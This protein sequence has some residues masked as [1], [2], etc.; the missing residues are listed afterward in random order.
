MQS[1]I[2]ASKELHDAF[3]ALVS[4]FPS[5]RGLI[6]SIKNEQLVPVETIKSSSNDFFDDLKTLDSLIKDN[7]AAY[8]VL[9]RYPNAPD[10]F[11]VV[12]YV[13][14]V[15][16]VRQK[17]LFAS[18]RLTL[19]RELGTERFRETLFATTKQ[20]LTAQGWHKHDESG[21]L[22]APLTEEE[23]TLQGVKDAEA[24]ASRGT[25]ARSSHVSSSVSFPISGD[26]LQAL[27][28][29]SDGHDN[30][31]QLVSFFSLHH[32]SVD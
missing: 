3:N 18:T 30:L 21:E 16:N 22:K 25:S 8:I 15:A 29:L 27:R 14:D 6:A 19:V 7:E 17:M 4:S 5:Q 28:G 10:G 1:G 31:V 13:P 24:E 32:R 23:Q 20:E 2:T 11:V 26:A 9:R 12:T